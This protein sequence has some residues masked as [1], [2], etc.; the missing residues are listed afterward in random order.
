MIVDDVFLTHGSA[1]VNLR[2]MEVDSELN[3]CHEHSEVTQAL[4]RRLWGIHTK[5]YGA[6]DDPE[7]AFKQWDFIIKRNASNQ[8]NHMAPYASLVGFMRNSASRL[9]LD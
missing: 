8:K 3:I 5:G 9:R 4:R 2:S 7:A 1:N 6:Q